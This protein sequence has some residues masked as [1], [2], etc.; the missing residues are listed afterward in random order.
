MNIHSETPKFR[1]N[2]ISLGPFERRALPWMAKRLPAWV[3][4]DH[5]TAV[6][7]VAAV[8]IALSYWLARYDL[9]WLWAVNIGLVIHWWGDSLDGTLARVRHIERNRY[10]FF[11]D[12]YSDTLAVFIIC[13][14]MGLSPIMDMRIALLIIIAYYGMMTLVNLV[15]MCRGVFKISFGGIGPTEIRL[16]IIVANTIVLVKHNPVYVIFGHP[17]TLFSIFGFAA[18]VGI[19]LYFLIFGEIERRKLSAL[20]P[21]P[22]HSF[23]SVPDA[24]PEVS[25]V[26]AK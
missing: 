8:F 14:G 18:A 11:V 19:G 22:N 1:I 26:N 24:H 25:T 4:P 12:H 2:D 10:G 15:S 13:L 21:T 9:N 6:G 7:Q 5:L 23:D 16:L 17:L 3:M 20:D